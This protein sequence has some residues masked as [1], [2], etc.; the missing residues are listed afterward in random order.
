M[1]ET[2]MISPFAKP[3]QQ[4]MMIHNS[5]FDD[6]MPKCNPTEWMVLCAIIRKTRGW[7]KEFDEISYSQLIKATSIK[8]KTTINKC[9]DG[10]EEKGMIKIRRG[11]IENS[12]T[13]YL[14]T[15][16]Q[17]PIPK[18]DIGLLQNL[19]QPISKNGNTKD[20]IKDN[21]KD[22]KDTESD[23]SVR[24]VLSKPDILDG[25]IRF[26]KQQITNQERLGIGL[27]NLY[28]YP[29]DVQ[30]VIKEFCRNWKIL[31]PPKGT[32][33][34]S[35]WINDAREIKKKLHNLHI[36]PEEAFAEAHYVW[37]TPPDFLK[38]NREDYDGKFNVS[39]LASV[40]KIVWEACS[41]IVDGRAKR[42]TKTYTNPDG[43][44]K[45]VE[46]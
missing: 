17:V 34:F 21:I 15:D 30:E 29:A 25:M 10:L 16:Y 13:Y 28:D 2:V 39:D 40:D 26:K 19:E 18:N 22:L 1:N 35:K 42:K 7:Q 44:K 46:I 5:V 8:S 43:S 45:V 32:K 31:P 24:E 12:N 36:P 14:N 37:K 9:I 23:D 38:I 6:I 33:G 4:Y 11:D 41:A 20:N 27:E 3:E